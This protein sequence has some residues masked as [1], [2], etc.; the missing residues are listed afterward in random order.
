M[1]NKMVDYLATKKIEV[2]RDFVG[3]PQTKEEG[4][5]EDDA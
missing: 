5:L 4:V 3:S 1:G 2:A